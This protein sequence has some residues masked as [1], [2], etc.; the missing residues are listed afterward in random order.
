MTAAVKDD[1]SNRRGAA[2]MAAKGTLPGDDGLWFFIAAEICLFGLLFGAFLN[3]RSGS[4]DIFR[5]AQRLMVPAFAFVNTTYLITSSWLVA[6]GVQFAR[7]N[8]TAAAPRSVT[9]AM[10]LGLFFVATKI[11]EYW[12]EIGMG[13]NPGTN[14]FF[15]FYFVV[16]GIHLAHVLGGLGLL[17]FVR[18]K[19]KDSVA[20][21]KRS[22][23]IE[24]GAT[25]WHMVDLLWLI[26]LALFYLLP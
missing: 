4:P 5:D 19:L 15:M 18:T 17:T 16:T 8:R 3:E 26:I 14:P 25:F 7:G 6:L 2:A 10:I 24:S 9:W 13:A 11:T 22:L 23:W 21:D 20:P 1:D 12:Y